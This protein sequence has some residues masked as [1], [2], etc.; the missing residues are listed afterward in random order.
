[1][2][3]APTAGYG[4]PGRGAR[5]WGVF[6]PV[7]GLA[8]PAS[9]QA[10][11]LATLRQLMDQVAA[12]GGSYV[13]VLPLLAQFLEEP[14]APSPYSPAS[15]LFWNELYLDLHKLGDAL[16]VRIPDA[17]PIRADHAIDYRAQYAWRRPIID[18]LARGRFDDESFLAGTASWA[19][20]KDA[21][22][23][24]AFR[25]LGELE[26]KGWQSWPGHMRDGTRLATSR[27]E[28][29]SLGAAAGA[30][31]EEFAARVDT[32]VFAQWMMQTQLEQLQGGRV[33]LYLD[34]PVGVNGDAYEVWR[35]RHLF[36]L[37]LAAG[38]PPDALFLGGQNWG[39]PPLSP[40]A[41]R[42]DRYRYF[43]QCVRHHM[44]VAG[45]LRIDHVMGMFRLYCVPHGRPAT[46]GVYVRYPHE[47]LLAVI[48]LESLRNVCIVAGEDLGTVPPHV[49]PTMTKPGMFRLHVGQWSF[50]SNPGDAPE[51]AHA[52]A[53]ASLDS[54]TAI[55]ALLPA[56]DNQTALAIA[57][58][59]LA[60]EIALRRGRASEAVRQFRAATALED[61]LFYA[62]P[63]TW[64]YPMRH[65]LGKAL[66]AANR[67]REAEAV[68][69][70][71]LSR[72]PNNGW[73]LFG[74]AQS[75]FRQGKVTEGRRVKRMFVE[76]WSAADIRLVA[77]RF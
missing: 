65:S 4:R 49:R 62:E 46:D 43:V 12:R 76:A 70:A 66:L 29:I 24:A 32:H 53:E 19:Q 10:G 5:R 54:V 45:M 52:E 21:W 18:A 1:V 9:G 47:E 27:L 28:A 39:L 16:D 14:F 23:Y 15:R 36:L 55:A 44:S 41:M 67:P 8:S 30:S 74:L 33:S 31:R 25:A 42:A 51:P 2:I 13:A 50:P 26:R 22:D 72:F 35:H 3:A 20:S 64:Y 59:A 17:P 6:A 56:G 11:D 69:R 58:L 48:T 77:S 75:L 73:S 7:Y 57:E 40:R 68:Y 38:A 71:D 34:L 61:G 63:P 60:G 37:D